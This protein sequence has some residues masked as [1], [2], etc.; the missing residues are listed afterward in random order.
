MNFLKKVL[1]P[2]LAV[3]GLAFAHSGIVAGGT[4]G[5]RQINAKTL[6]Q[7]NVVVGTGGTVAADAWA[8]TR[9]GIY[10]VN[11]KRSAFLDYAATLSGDFFVTVGL[12]DYLDLGVSLPLYYDHASEG[13]AGGM[14]MLNVLFVFFGQRLGNISVK[15]KTRFCPIH[16]SKLMN[17]D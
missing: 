14:N 13:P 8:F 5:L 16:L 3:A 12:L 4:E 2:A 6:G 17:Q 15:N 7:W 10:E 11:G 9:G 1:A